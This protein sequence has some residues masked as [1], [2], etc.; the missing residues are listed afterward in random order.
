MV[1]P[2]KLTA[3]QTLAEW[4]QTLN[5]DALPEGMRRACTHTVIDTL[6][7]SIAA[8]HTDYVGAPRYAWPVEGPLPVFACP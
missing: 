2:A 3:A 4:L 7:P 6:G 8:T 1:E 5:P